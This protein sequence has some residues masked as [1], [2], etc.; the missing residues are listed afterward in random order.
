MSAGLPAWDFLHR[1]TGTVYGFR[2]YHPRTGR[3]VFLY[4]GKTIRKAWERRIAEHL[5]GT[6]TTPA[7]PWADTVLGWR[8]GCTVDEVIRA[9]GAFVIWRRVTTPLVVTLAEVWLGIWLRWPLYNH[10][11]NQHNPRRIPISVAVEQRRARDR[12]R[13]ARDP[14]TTRAQRVSVG[15][16]RVVAGRGALLLGRVMVGLLLAVAG[17]AVLTLAW[18]H[19]ELGV[20][21]IGM[22]P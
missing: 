15:L 5:F 8:P 22:V 6:E 18:Q 9:G 11:W 13:V 1:V 17:V 12:G 20:D 10:Q 4:G 21:D 16:G 7:K 3:V 2:G 14:L 19:P